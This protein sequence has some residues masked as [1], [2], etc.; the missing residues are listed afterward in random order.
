MHALLDVNVLVAMLDG[1]H[2]DHERATDW[3]LDHAEAGWAS[4]P[5]TQNGCL[6]ILSQPGYPQP[7]PLLEVEARLRDFTDKPN[8]R[9]WPDSVSLL[10]QN[11]FALRYSHGARQLTDIYL[12]GL[13]VENGGRLVTFD[14]RI[15]R[16][17]VPGAD[18]D[19]LLILA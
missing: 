17:A 7:V 14:Q 19:N 15:S 2:S 8:H 1:T 3:F 11:R 6:R 5:L 4:C 16:H 9:F 13:A 12:L 18:E 10:D